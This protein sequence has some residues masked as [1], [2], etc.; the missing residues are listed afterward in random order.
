MEMLSPWSFCVRCVWRM[1]STAIE[2]PS[3]E[4]RRGLAAC[5][6][7]SGSLRTLRPWAAEVCNRP[8]PNHTPDLA[9]QEDLLKRCSGT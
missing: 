8:L 3:L 5:Q 4:E 9:G 6:K 7:W 2:C 1:H